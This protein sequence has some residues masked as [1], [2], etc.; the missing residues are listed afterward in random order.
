MLTRMTMSSALAEARE[1]ESE[2]RGWIEDAVE[3]DAVGSLVK[4]RW[5]QGEHGGMGF[6]GA[7]RV[8]VRVVARVRVYGVPSRE[9]CFW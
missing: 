9:T 7:V 3:G 8:V 5:P 2:S 6:E 1:V 4:G